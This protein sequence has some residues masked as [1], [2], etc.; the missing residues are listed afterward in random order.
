MPEVETANANQVQS[1]SDNSKNSGKCTANSAVVKPDS[2]NVSRTWVIDDFDIGRPLGKGKFGS[3]FV[4]RSKEEK[5]VVALKVLFK[6]QIEKHNVKHQVKREIEIQYHL[7]HPNILRCKGYFHDQQRVYII[8]EFADGGELYNRLKKKGRL[9]EPEAA[10]YVRQLADALS[11]CH[12]KK[13]IHRDIK[14]ENILL[15]RKGNVKIADFGWAVV[16]SHSRRETICGTLDYLPPEM[17]CGGTHDHTVDNWAIGIL[18]H[19]MLVGRPPFEF[20]DQNQTL[21]AIKT[22]RFIIPKFVSDGPSDLIRRL[23][24][25]EPCMRLPLSGVLAHPWVVSMS[26]LA[27]SEM[28]RHTVPRQ[29]SDQ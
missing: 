29:N 21:A 14:P 8:L 1:Q 17:I 23:V 9:E 7:M 10:K 20:P 2:R 12:A 11:Y 25:K 19:E 13:V 18:L 24:V 28:N 27:S 3:V 4:A 15:D 6:D 16:S 22:C 26:N 5:I